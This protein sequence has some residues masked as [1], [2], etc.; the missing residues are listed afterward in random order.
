MKAV[1]DVVMEVL[2][3]REK[4]WIDSNKILSLADRLDL[5]DIEAKIYFLRELTAIVRRVSM[6]IYKDSEERIRL[7]EAVQEAL[8]AAIEEEQELLEG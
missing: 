2:P 6:K 5:D 8:D 1:H 4:R 3:L 7:I